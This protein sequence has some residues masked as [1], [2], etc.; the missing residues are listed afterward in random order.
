[1]HGGVERGDLYRIWNSTTGGDEWFYRASDK[2]CDLRGFTDKFY[3]IWDFLAQAKQAGPCGDHH[4]QGTRWQFENQDVSL[5]GCI[6]N[7]GKTPI[8][9]DVRLHREDRGFFVM[10]QKWNGVAPAPTVFTLPATC[11]K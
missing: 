4:N 11:Q 6:S 1:M 10:F 3:G 8:F 9:H 7:D 2:K 5:D